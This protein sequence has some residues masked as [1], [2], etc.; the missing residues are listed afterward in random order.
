[1]GAPLHGPD[2]HPAREGLQR[3]LWLLVLGHVAKPRL[4][5]LRTSLPLH[6]IVVLPSGDGGE[7]T[8]REHGQEMVMLR[9]CPGGKGGLHWLGCAN[10]HSG[11]WR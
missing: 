8:V 5:M 10:F 1:M 11:A 3:V 9:R 6:P 7:G 4:E 2:P